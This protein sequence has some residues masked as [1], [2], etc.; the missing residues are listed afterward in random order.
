MESASAGAAIRPQG[1]QPD[2]PRLL[3]PTDVARRLKVHRNTVYRLIETGELPALQLGGRG[4]T[5]RVD[6]Q[7][8]ERWLYGQGEAE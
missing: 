4:Y 6:E 8:L 1:R 7:E 3:R 2:P 5:V